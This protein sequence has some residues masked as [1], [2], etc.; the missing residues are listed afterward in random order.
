MSGCG[1]SSGDG[2]GRPRDVA[3]FGADVYTI[4][5][6]GRITTREL[7]TLVAAGLDAGLW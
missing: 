2:P 3:Q 5:L 1:G 7:G 6:I 4:N